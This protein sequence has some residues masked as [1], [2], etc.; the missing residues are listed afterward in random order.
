VRKNLG[1]LKKYFGRVK[2]WAAMAAALTLLLVAYY[3]FQGARYLKSS[4]QET[5]LVSERSKLLGELKRQPNPEE[6]IAAELQTAKDTLAQYQA[7]F[8]YPESDDL[9]N[10]VVAT[11]REHGLSLTSVSGADREPF[12]LDGIEYHTQG[13]TMNIEGD[14]DGIYSFLTD[15][16]QKTQMVEVSTIRLARGGGDEVV[17]NAQLKYYLTPKPLDAASQAQTAAS[18]KSGSA[19]KPAKPG[20][21]TK[22]DS[23]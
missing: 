12:P 16:H 5:M 19:Q 10:V 21:K 20:S 7:L 13:M 17:A 8:N 6:V 3:G 14:L 15:L 1:D 23:K 2:P 4:E 9:I 11:A 22:S 18:S